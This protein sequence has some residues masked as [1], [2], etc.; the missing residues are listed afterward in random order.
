LLFGCSTVRAVQL[1]TPSGAPLEWRITCEKSFRP[2]EREAEER[3]GASYTE[4]ERNVLEE[5]QARVDRT[6]LTRSAPENAMGREFRAELMVSCTS[7]GPDL[8]PK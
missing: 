6:G 5:G 2:C 3:C 4:L 8:V 7:T 1:Q